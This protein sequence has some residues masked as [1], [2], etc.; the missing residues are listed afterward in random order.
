LRELEDQSITLLRKAFTL[1]QKLSAAL[2][3]FRRVS[4]RS[5]LN[6]LKRFR[7]PRSKC[8]SVWTRHYSSPELPSLPTS[9]GNVDS[10]RRNQKLHK[11]KLRRLAKGLLKYGIPLCSD[12]LVFAIMSTFPEPSKAS[13]KFL[14]DLMGMRRQN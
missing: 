3:E 7:A 8:N 5:R 2:V 12:D 11:V 13:E 1:V 6:Y 10:T 9:R 14:K 4:R